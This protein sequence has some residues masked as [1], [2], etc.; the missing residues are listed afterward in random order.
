MSD[1]IIKQI[2]RKIKRFQKGKILFIADFSELGSDEAI[3]QS[4]Q[5]LTKKNLIIRLSQ[6]IYYFPKES[7]T[8]KSIIYP[9]AEQIAR[10]IA[11]RDKAR[12]IPTGSYSLYKLGLTNQVPINVVYLTDGSARKIIVGNQKIIFKKTSPKNLAVNH[13]L[14]N[15]II[16]G[17][18]ELGKNNIDNSV[19]DKL[20]EV[21]ILSGEKD[22][23]KN[24]MKN[25]PAWI[26]KIVLQIIKETER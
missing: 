20:K 7:K 3:R 5:R 25:A 15:L 6:G 26:K 21:I 23:V 13:T 12:I 17:L 8:L 16:Q 19:L 10:A 1:S 14:S 4:L 18:K 11:L 22:T 24:Q 2:E 9:T